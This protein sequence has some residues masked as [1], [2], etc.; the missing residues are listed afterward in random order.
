MIEQKELEK[1]IKEADNIILKLIDENKIIIN[2]SEKE[3]MRF[4]SF[5]IKQAN[6]S[7][8]ASDL[9]YDISTKKESKEFHKL[10]PDYECFLWVLNSAYYSMFYAVQALL[11]YRGVRILVE[12]GI[13]KITANALI[14]FC[15]KNNFIAKELYT[16]FVRSQIEAAELLNLEDFKG[17]AIDLTEKFFHESEK[18]S[19]FTYETGKEVK[20]AHAT[21]SLQRAKEFLNEIEKILFKDH[22]T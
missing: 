1:Q 15:I 7:L 13:H 21:T 11:A 9:L 17:R 5:Y 19:K 4:I 16:Q 22:L 14:Y 8:I 6:L 18:R 12:Q 10:S 3:K 20:Q 2:L